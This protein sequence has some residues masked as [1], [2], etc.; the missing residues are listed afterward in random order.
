MKPVTVLVVDDEADLL[1]LIRFNLERRGYQVLT[2][3][4][5]VSALELAARHVPDLIILDLLLPQ[6]NGREVAGT[7]KRDAAL[8][9]IPII[10]L[11][12]LSQEADVI[13]GLQL[14]AD[15]Y[16]TKPF[17]IDVLLAR[18]S[19]VLRR[20]DSPIEEKLAVRAG[21]ILI[22]RA[23]HRVEVSGQEIGLTL[24]EYK[25]LDALVAARSRVLSRDQL[26]SK[27][28]GPDVAV[29]DRTIDVHITSLRRK[30]GEA[31][32]LVETVRGVGYRFADV[33]SR[34]PALTS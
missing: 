24:T 32:D 8:R 19:A 29:T 28:M 9:S 31:R 14:G 33:W 12:A 16:V 4:D 2:A 26:M 21:A 27:V 25:L 5:G 17:S 22:D 6:M 13:T 1:D 18:V 15:D 11:T 7:L 23:R 34:A 20:G 30:L 10:M 3:A